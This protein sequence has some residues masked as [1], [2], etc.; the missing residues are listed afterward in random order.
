MED[1]KSIDIGY[2][3][4]FRDSALI[5]RCPS[6]QNLVNIPSVITHNPPIGNGALG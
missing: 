2:T 1:F 3:K 4:G 6:E 5:N